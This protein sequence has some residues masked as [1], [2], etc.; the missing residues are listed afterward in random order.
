MKTSLKEFSRAEVKASLRQGNTYWFGAADGLYRY[1]AGADKA[2][3]VA[4]WSGRE[5]RALGPAKSGLWLVAGDEHDQAAYRLDAEGRE[6]EKIPLPPG[7]KGKAISGING[8]LWLGVKTGVFRHDAKGWR[9]VFGGNGKAET[10]A[11]WEQPG[12]VR[13]SIKKLAPDDKPALVT[14]GDDG[15]NWTV[16]TMPEYQDLYLA[17]DDQTIITRW[18][19]ARRRDSVK[20]GYKKHPLTAGW[21]EN[22]ATAVLDGEKL[23]MMPRSRVKIAVHHPLMA[24]AEHLHPTPAGAI[25]AGSQGAYEIA[26]GTG[27]VR[28]LMPHTAPKEPMG[29]TKKLYVLD[30]GAAVATATFGVF[31][32][33]DGL[34]SWKQSDSEWSVLDAE[35]LTK[36]EDGTWWLLCQRGL[37]WSKDNGQSW[38]YQK[39]K[40]PGRHYCEFRSI[41]VAEGK[42]Y[43]GTK[44]GLFVGLAMPAGNIEIAPHD[45]FGTRVVEGLAF[46][47]AKRSLYTVDHD[48]RCERIDLATGK[49]A[50][51][52]SVPGGEVKLALLGDGTLLVAGGEKVVAVG[53]GGAVDARPSGA[54]GKFSLTQAGERVLLWSRD[55]AW[56]RQ[57]NGAWSG[58]ANWPEGVR[59]ASIDAKR[60]CAYTTD[61][62]YLHRVAL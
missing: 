10:I 43:L 2:V 12:K 38:N 56:L 49:V 20:A 32:S 48:G 39:F 7:A 24:E 42:L 4:A 54:S 33:T 62:R 3:P 44:A 52:A 14:S 19:G 57:G 27:Q 23:E 17:A 46:D 35:G 47:A 26:A 40:V 28:D 25:F 53:A 30:D 13:A 58:V 18:R 29:K 31:R 16:E 37:F 41:A 8:A 34:E 51:V 6:Q 55:G 45:H 9:Q 1:E 60:N 61:R 50:D 59:H 22:G 21:L 36:A 15:Q 11:I 5:V